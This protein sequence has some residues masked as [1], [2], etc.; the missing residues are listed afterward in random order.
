V[1]EVD[2]ETIVQ[3]AC[4]KFP[5]ARPRII[6]DNRPPLIA[7]DFKTFIRLSGMTHVRTAPYYPQ[8][9]GKIVG[10]HRH[11]TGPL[12]NLSPLRPSRDDGPCCRGQ[13]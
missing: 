10:F 6:S 9:N 12:Q 7:R 13:R 8:S 5:E 3:R 1:R 11:G 4:E 2:V